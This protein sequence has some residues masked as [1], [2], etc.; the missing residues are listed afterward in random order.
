MILKTTCK[1]CANKLYITSFIYSFSRSYR[2]L[3]SPMEDNFI[4]YMKTH[5]ALMHPERI[6]FSVGIVSH[7]SNC[8][9][10]HHFVMVSIPPFLLNK[11]KR[12]QFLF[13]TSFSLFS[14]S[15]YS[16]TFN[17]KDTHQYEAQFRTNQ[18]TLPMRMMKV[19]KTST[20]STDLLPTVRAQPNYEVLPLGSDRRMRK[21]LCK[22]LLATL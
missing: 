5:L 9:Q 15:I 12:K 14:I 19:T 17:L 10:L 2:R 18:V 22:I 8:H 11:F 13:Y 3:I 21:D 1:L 6:F 4:S 20:H 7:H 16:L